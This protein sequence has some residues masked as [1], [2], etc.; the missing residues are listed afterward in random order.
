[1]DA[2]TAKSLESTFIESGR[3]LDE[4]DGEGSRRTT[5]FSTSRITVNMMPIGWP[6]RAQLT[7]NAFGHFP[8]VHWTG[9]PWAFDLVFVQ[10]EHF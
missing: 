6:P 10:A 8:F 3:L 1:M 2:T 5:S 4:L 7:W 9:A